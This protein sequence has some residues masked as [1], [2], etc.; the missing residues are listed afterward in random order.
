MFY[1]SI[2]SGLKFDGEYIISYLL[3]NGYEH[4]LDKKQKRDK[5]F[6]T[7]ISGMG[8][9]YCIEIY[10]NVKNKRHMNKVKIFDSYKILDFSVEYIAK[11]FNLPIRKLEIDYEE[12]REVGHVLTEQEV[13][14]IR[15]DVEIM[16]RALKIMFDYGLT[17]MTIGSCALNNYR[18]MTRF[19]NNYYPLLDLE[20]DDFIRLSYKGG[21]TY[22]SPKYKEKVVKNGIV[23]DVNS[24][25]P[26][27]MYDKPLPFG[28]PIMF[29]GKYEY[30]FLYPLYIQKITCS[31]ELKPNKIP[32]IQLKKSLMF[33]PTEYIESSKGQMITLTL[34]SVDLELFLENYD[35]KHERYDGGFKFKEIYGLFTEYMDHWASEKIKAKKD[36]NRALY[37]ISKKMMNSLYGKFS[38]SCHVRSKIPFLD[39]DGIVRYEITEDKI[40]KGLYIPVGAFITAYAR[41]KTIR[42]SQAI[43]DYTM[44]KYGK[45]YYIY[46]DTD[47]IH[48]LELPEEELKQFIDIDD[49]KIGFWKLENRW[50]KA[51][52]IRSKCYIEDIVLSKEEYEKGI[53]EIDDGTFSKDKNGYYRLSAT[54][55]GLPKALGRYVNFN[56]FEIG[57]SILASDITKKHKL[58]YKHVNGGVMLV[59]TDFSI[60]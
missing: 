12:F 57:F 37:L 40:E 49:Y 30:D 42:T 44:E 23:L 59:S 47:S 18:K 4:I 22:L 28:K 34:T 38:K 3:K 55:A 29:E 7:L 20:S 15:N 11:E 31:F 53:K 16:A 5:T 26:S 52:F 25:Y 36:G 46:S 39:S 2:I 51:K 54:I 27:V 41:E 21:F 1:I 10:F 19:F 60:K 48:M 35:I 45:D 6:T 58:T 17:N 13:D 56:N 43:R 50:R 8:Q 24:L 33:L 14:Y 32:T 9:F